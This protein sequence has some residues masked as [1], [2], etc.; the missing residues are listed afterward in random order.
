MT[1]SVT[2][3]TP[4]TD[5]LYSV[6]LAGGNARAWTVENIVSGG[7]V[8]S[9]NANQQPDEDAYWLAIKHGESN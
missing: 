8:I 5:G 1:S 4:F 6:A 2:F 9:T 7:F 3:I